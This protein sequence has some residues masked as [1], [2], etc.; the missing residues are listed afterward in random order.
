M[1]ILPGFTG[2]SGF[3]GREGD[4]RKTNSYKGIGQFVDLRGVGGRLDKK[5]GNALY[6][7]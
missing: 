2:K 6:V 1:I 4:S 5:E 3:R 7:D